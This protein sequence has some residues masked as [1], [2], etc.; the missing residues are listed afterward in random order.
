MW[1]CVLLSTDIC[2]SA[3]GLSW[4]DPCWHLGRSYGRRNEIYTALGG[5]P[6][7]LCVDFLGPLQVYDNLAWCTSKEL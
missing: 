6:I 1:G 5:F 7:P 2:H 4:N 3:D